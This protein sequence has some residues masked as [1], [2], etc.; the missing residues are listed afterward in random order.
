MRESKESFYALKV[1]RIGYPQRWKKLGSRFKKHW[2]GQ[3]Q[4]VSLVARHPYPLPKKGKPGAWVKARTQATGV[5]A[6]RLRKCNA[7][8]HAAPVRMVERWM[9]WGGWTTAYLFEVTG[10]HLRWDATEDKV[11]FM[12]GRLVRELTDVQ[13]RTVVDEIPHL[14]P[15]ESEPTRD[16]AKRA[17]LKALKLKVADMDKVIW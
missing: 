6:R 15:F 1:M 14:D 3:E 11:V 16:Q 13:Y 9:A 12:K 4:L 5:F 2:G 10:P 8:I 7:G 17:I